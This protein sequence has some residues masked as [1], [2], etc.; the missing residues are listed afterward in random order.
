MATSQVSDR[1]LARH[2]DEQIAA[3]QAVLSALEAEQLALRHRDGDALLQAVNGKA[4]S[5]ARADQLEQRRQAMMADLGLADRRTAVGRQF[6][7]DAGISQRWQQVLALTRQCRAV[8]ESNGLFIRGQRRRVD[9]T[10]QI[11]RGGSSAVAEYGPGG[12]GRS[13][14]SSRTLASF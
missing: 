5:V 6:S 8:N 2:L 10:L 12:E 1:D 9:A 7:A 14:S 3:M 13:R 4:T 11:L